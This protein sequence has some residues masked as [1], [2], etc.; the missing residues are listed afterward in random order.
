MRET[1]F[2]IANSFRPYDGSSAVKRDGRRRGD[3]LEDAEWLAERFGA[4]RPRLARI[5]QRILG[6]AAEADDALQESWLR[7]G[8]ADVARATNLEG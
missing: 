7:I 8:R 5:A 6:S 2:K 3:C 1:S 4:A